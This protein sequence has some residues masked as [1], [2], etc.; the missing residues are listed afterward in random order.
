MDSGKFLISAGGILLFFAIWG[1]FRCNTGVTDLTK[2]YIVQTSIDG[3]D[4]RQQCNNYIYTENFLNAVN[5]K[6]TIQWRRALIISFGSAFITYLL[7]YNFR[8]LE[9]KDWAL[10]IFVTFVLNWSI[11]GYNDYHVRSNT[12][13]AIK[14]TMQNSA[15][16]FTNDKACNVFATLAL[17]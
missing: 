12:S 2:Q 4:A 3:T 17:Q 5:K 8:L 15:S 10:L 16:T 9:S 6:S 11:G 7:M 1:E 13:Q 14:T